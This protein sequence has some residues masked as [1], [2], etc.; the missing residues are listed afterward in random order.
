MNLQLEDRLKLTDRFRWIASNIPIPNDH[1]S[2]LRSLKASGFEPKVIYDIGACVLQWTTEAKRLWPDAQYVLFDAFEEPEYLY[3]QS[4]Y[5]YS[6]GVLGNATGVSVKW[7]QNA[8][9]FA[10]NSYYKE[11]DDVVF[12]PEN[13][14]DR[15]TVAW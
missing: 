4:G 13:Y 6:V 2:Y 1:V 5:D 10:G 7:Y 15:R 14:F 12:A 9:Y 3:K 8:T 11:L